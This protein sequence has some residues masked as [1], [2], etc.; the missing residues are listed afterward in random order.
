[1]R[2]QLDGEDPAGAVSRLEERAGP[3]PAD[4]SEVVRLRRVEPDAVPRDGVPAD[5]E[6]RHQLSPLPPPTPRSP[7][8]LILSPPGE[9]EGRPAV[10]LDQF[11][12]LEALRG[13]GAD[14]GRNLVDEEAARDQPAVMRRRSREG[15]RR[16]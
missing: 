11:L 8:G 2:D 13:E 1:E 4:A 6:S 3:Q 10:V 15:P 16:G 9:G 7:P 5:E 12:E 14:D